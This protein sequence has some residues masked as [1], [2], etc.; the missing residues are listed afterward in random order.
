MAP[1]KLYTPVLLIA[2]VSL[3]AACGEGGYS[4]ETEYYYDSSHDHH[5]SDHQYAHDEPELYQFHIIDTYETNTEFDTHTFL[6]LSPYENGG[7]FEIYWETESR[8]EYVVEFLFNTQPSPFG[9]RTISQE[10][11]GPYDY[12]DDNQY[13]FCEYTSN[14][15]LACESSSGDYSE[16]YIGDQLDTIP[17]DAYMILQVCDTQFFYCEYEARQVS[18]E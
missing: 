2:L 10:Y 7:E 9:A 17:Q 3:L 11:C 6:A 14:L 5:E 15:Y 18:M 13:Q 1:K 16:R 4:V 12:C 8:D